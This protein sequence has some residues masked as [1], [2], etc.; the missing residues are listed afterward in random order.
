MHLELK[1]SEAQILRK[2]LQ[3]YLS[4]LRQEI[5]KTEKHDW[6]VALH[7]EEEVLKGIA[8]R[9]HADAHHSMEG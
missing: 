8:S 6:R 7:H 3:A 9:L 1:E 4:E 2:A 5:V